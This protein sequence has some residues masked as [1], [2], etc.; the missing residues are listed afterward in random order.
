MHV[1]DLDA[2]A[3]RA[4]NGDRDAEREFFGALLPLVNRYCRLRL[5]T[6]ERAV[7]SAEDV[8]QEVLLAVGTVLHRYRPGTGS[9]LAFVYGIAAHKVTDAQRVLYRSR[10]FAC[11][12][13]HN[14]E[15]REPGPEE[16]VLAEGVQAPMRHAL[17]R[18]PERQRE[19]LVLRTMLGFSVEETAQAVRC[20][21]GAVRIAQHRALAT[22]R[23]LSVPR[24]AR[25]WRE[26]PARTRRDQ[27]A[28]LS[29]SLHAQ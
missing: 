6:S 25:G 2:C 12:E 29:I 18:L 14:D 13:M 9:V 20:S 24:T 22:L 3:V 1:T 21:A 5:G 10:S 16:C 28:R 15:G 8:T 4:T 7:L 17:S 11:P 26:C 23:E 27:I 19:V